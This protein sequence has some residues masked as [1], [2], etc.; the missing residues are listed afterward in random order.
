MKRFSSWEG[1]VEAGGRG[2]GRCKS[3]EWQ[4]TEVRGLCNNAEELVFILRA[5]EAFG[6]I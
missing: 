1:G 5:T 2:T 4:G 3:V 6:R